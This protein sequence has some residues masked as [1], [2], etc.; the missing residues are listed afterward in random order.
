MQRTTP[1]STRGLL[2]QVGEQA[3]RHQHHYLANPLRP[4]P[5]AMARS[6]LMSQVVGSQ[7]EMTACGARRG[8]S[9]GHSPAS[10]SLSPP[11]ARVH[12]I[13]C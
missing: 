13:Q 12:T 11:H 9:Q 7:T 5:Q 4:S 1:T 6:N 8:R 10:Q 2:M 3:G